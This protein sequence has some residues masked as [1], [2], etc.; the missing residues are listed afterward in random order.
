MAFTD[1]LIDHADVHVTIVDRRHGPG[2]HWLDA[3]PFVRLHQASQF[4]GV[5]STVL[6]P[7]TLQAHGPEVGLH[8]RAG[9][10]HHLREFI[11]ALEVQAA[12]RLNELTH[13]AATEL[14]RATQRHTRAGERSYERSATLTAV[15]S[16]AAPLGSGA[17]QAEHVATVSTPR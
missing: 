5:A 8:D 3:Y 10:L 16:L 2:G 6:G 4:Y 9:C 1:S 7:G 13:S 17:L 15:P 11:D 14:A 12:R